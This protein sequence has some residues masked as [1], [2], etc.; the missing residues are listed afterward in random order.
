[1]HKHLLK[2]HS[3]EHVQ[4]NP[5]QVTGHYNTYNHQWQLQLFPIDA[6]YSFNEL[7]AKRKHAAFLNSSPSEVNLTVNNIGVSAHLVCQI[8]G[9][10]YLLLVEQ[11]R[12]DFQDTVLKLISGYVSSKS[13]YYPEQAIAEEITQECLMVYK[14]QY[15]AQWQDHSG[16]VLPDPEYN[17]LTVDT[18]KRLT[19][20]PS[21]ISSPQQISIGAAQCAPHVN[22]Y[23]HVP[24]NSLQLVYHWRVTFQDLHKLSCYFVDELFNETDQCLETTWNKSDKCYFAELQF[25]QLTGAIF[26]LEAGQLKPVDLQNALFSEYFCERK[27]LMVF[28]NHAVK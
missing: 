8:N 4:F 12:K 28:D 10:D 25:D 27:G 26:Q 5:Y 19:L 21:L 20:V 17:D 1:M 2:S 24:T 16:Q 23:I 15:L 11:R 18:D 9:I 7:Q 6:P 22:S 14:D 13:S 3:A